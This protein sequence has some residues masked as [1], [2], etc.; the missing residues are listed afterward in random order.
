MQITGYNLSGGSCSQAVSGSNKHMLVH[1]ACGEWIKIRYM[2][3][4]RSLHPDFIFYVF[5]SPFFL[6]QQITNLVYS[7]LGT[8]NIVHVCRFLFQILGYRYVRTLID[9]FNILTC[10]QVGMLLVHNLQSKEC[11]ISLF[12]STW[13]ICKHFSFW[14]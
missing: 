3:R 13:Y 8:F 9:S 6:L 2:R 1:V 7:I 10:Y 11:N 14:Q 12:S 5:L 4:I